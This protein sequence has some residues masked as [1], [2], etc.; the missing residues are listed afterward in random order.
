MP[1]SIRMTCPKN[2]ETVET[3]TQTDNVQKYYIRT[4]QD[5]TDGSENVGDGEDGF[6]S[7]NLPLSQYKYTK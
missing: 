3:D 1:C 4:V 6:K 5:S 7:D 2:Q